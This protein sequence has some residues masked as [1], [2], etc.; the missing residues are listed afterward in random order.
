MNQNSKQLQVFYKNCL[1]GIL[2]Q[3]SRYKVA[4]EYSEEW[5]E[6]G[7][8]ISPFSLPLTKQV[9]VPTKN[10]FSGLFGTFADSLINVG[11]TAGIKKDKCLYLAETIQK[12]VRDMLEEYLR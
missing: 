6:N 11:I 12:C 7:F 10:Y 9:F 4:F 2:A 1:V 3:I 5:V 8:S